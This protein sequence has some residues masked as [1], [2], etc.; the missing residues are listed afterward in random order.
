MI[1]QSKTDSAPGIRH[2]IF[3]V[4]H[5][6]PDTDTIASAIGYAWLR[7]E[8]DGE[9][10]IAARAGTVNVQT[11][12]ALRHFS[13]ETPVLLEDAAP[14]FFTIAHRV[15]PVSPQSPLSEAWRL[16]AES[17]RAVPV[18]D[19]VCNPVGMVTGLS[20]FRYLSGHLDMADA[21]L[22]ALIGVPCGEACDC[23][24][25]RF[26]ANDRISDYLTEVTNTER[27]DFWVVDGDGK[28]VGTCTRADM[29]HPPRVRLILVDHNEASQAVNGLGEADVLEVLDHHRLATINT[30]MPIAFHVDTVGSCSTLVAERMRMARLTPPPD[31]AGMLLSGLLADTLMFRSP[32]TTPRDRASGT[33]LS[34]MAFGVEE[35]DTRMQEYGLELLHAGADLQGRTAEDIV[36][37]DCK[38]FTSG[39][40]KFSVSQVEVTHFQVLLERLDNVRAALRTLQDQRSSDF[41]V[42]MVTDIIQNDSLLVGVGN[43]RYLER[44]PFSRKGEGLWDLPGVVS[45]KKQLLPTLLGMLQ[46]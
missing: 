43:N 11:A 46:G 45:R 6:N 7:R 24:V 15:K 40:V 27:D 37:A 17:E 12:F 39:P 13:A 4:G 38:I 25:P 2:S 3:V 1:G 31:V 33:W 30:T 14:R 9:D 18:V 28:Y 26:N 36:S 8:R 41:A 22:R 16:S 20:V 19:E 32:T 23:A 10:A 44:L 5:K 35:A 34:W 42:L 21:P 29:L